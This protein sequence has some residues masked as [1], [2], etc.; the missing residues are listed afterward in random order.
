MEATK[1]TGP[2]RMPLAP[3]LGLEEERAQD[4]LPRLLDYVK[5]N[6]WKQVVQYL[7]QDPSLSRREVSMVCQGENSKCLLVHLLSGSQSTPISVIDTLVTLNPGSLLQPDERG[8][9][10]PIHLAVVKGASHTV[11]QQLCNARPQALQVADEEGN[12]PV[13]YA[14]MY[15]SS[16]ILRLI[17]QAYPEACRVLN[18]RD[19]FPLHLVC[20]RCFDAD[21]ISPG[22]L[23]FNIDAH[24]NAVEV[25]DRFGRMPLHL[26][27]EVQQPQRELLETLIRRYPPALVHRD[28]ARNTPLML[29]KKKRNFE[30]S[31]RYEL[32]VSSLAACTQ[33][34]R[35]KQNPYLPAFLFVSQSKK[36]KS[37]NVNLYHCYG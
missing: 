12:H 4:L 33:R 32:L 34:E 31:Q 3:T 36:T 10:L 11:I 15:G 35:K 26:A 1:K 25:C 27:S 16:S 20:A 6:K 24:P 21:A 30:D 13:H 18:G 5:G 9:R 22:D 17:V 8:G 19:R 29:A 37:K 2:Q 28:K 23:D 7:E 14:A